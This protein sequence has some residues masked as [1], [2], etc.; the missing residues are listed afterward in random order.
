LG[1]GAFPLESR[2]QPVSKLKIGW[3]LL[4]ASHICAPPRRRVQRLSTPPANA[5]P[6]NFA[7]WPLQP[8]EG[9][10]MSPPAEG[11]LP[12]S[13]METADQRAASTASGEGARGTRSTE[14]RDSVTAVIIAALEG[15]EG[16]E[17]DVF[18]EEE[19]KE[20]RTL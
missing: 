12:V 4:K 7:R 2:S 20:V 17:V 11:G 18:H 3:D 1:I 16:E 6:S 10:R 9:D 8:Q 5:N 13:D 19:G 15:G 14:K